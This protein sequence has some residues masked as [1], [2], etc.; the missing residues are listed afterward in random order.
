MPGPHPIRRT[1]PR[2]SARGAR[3][4]VRETGSA[5]EPKL[6]SPG[7]ERPL[8]L[9]LLLVVLLFRRFLLCLWGFGGRAS[10]ELI[11]NGGGDVVLIID[12]KK[13]GRARASGGGVTVAAFCAGIDD[14]RVT[15]GL[16]LAIY[17]RADFLKDA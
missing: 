1:H 12:V 15:R 8:L 6:S 17:R 3:D 5:A 2:H 11:E 13:D 4:A 10:I 14:Q 7:E 9:V 16:C